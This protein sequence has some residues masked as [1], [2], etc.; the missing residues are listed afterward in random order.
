MRT[1]RIERATRETEISLE[2][3]LDGEGKADLTTGIGFLDHMLE[4]CAAHAM[5]DLN[6][7]A[8]GDLHVDQHHTV[9]DVG[10]CLGTALQEA[11]G[12]KRGISRYGHCTLPMDDSL[13]TTAIDLGGRPHLVWKVD[14][15]AGRIGDFDSELL[16]EFWQAF[17]NTAMANVHVILHHGLNSHHVAEAIFK[18]AARS[19][20]AAVERDPRQAGVPSTKGN[21]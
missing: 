4:L 5:F 1:A 21:L 15:P 9:E 2:I 16:R 8:Q 19:L 7:Q 3:C 10:L 11:L 13:V 6:V 17:A 20:R 12:D 14:I 18:S